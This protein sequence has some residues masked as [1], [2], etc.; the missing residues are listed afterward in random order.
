[1][2][3]TVTQQFQSIEHRL[4]RH[5][6][7][8]ASSRLNYSVMIV[9]ALYGTPFFRRTPGARFVVVTFHRVVHDPR[10]GQDISFRV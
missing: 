2:L 3:L 5:F 8:S 6:D 1:M 9:F 4:G 7:A 10:D